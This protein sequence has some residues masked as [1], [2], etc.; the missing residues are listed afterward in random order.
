MKI[1]TKENN[2]N[3]VELT[4]EELINL[5]KEV[6]FQ[7]FK[8]TRMPEIEKYEAQA[9]DYIE[10]NTST[11]YADDY[12]LKKYLGYDDT[13]RYYMDLVEWVGGFDQL[14]ELTK[15]LL[16]EYGFTQVT[17]SILVVVIQ[18]ELEGHY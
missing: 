1:I 9:K 16:D 15:R 2:A 18:D 11:H 6:R 4:D 8:K 12:E 3:V 17:F 13:Y 10:N 5:E 7:E 14:F